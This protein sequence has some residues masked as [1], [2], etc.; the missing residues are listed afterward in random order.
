MTEESLSGTSS[1]KTRRTGHMGRIILD[2][3]KRLNAVDLDMAEGIARTLE[4]WRND[5]KV[6]VVVLESSSPRAFCAG[7]DLKKICELLQIEGADEAFRQMSRVYA[8]MQQIAA[9]P[10][11]TVSVLDGI[12]MGGGIGLGG[13]ATYRIVTE[14]SVVAMPETAIGLT[15]DAGGSW[16]LSR[17]PGFS[18]LRNA[19][20]GN[21]MDGQAAITMGFADTLIASEALPTFLDQLADKL[22]QDVFSA[23]PP[24]PQSVSVQSLDTCYNAPDLDHAIR[25]LT[26]HDSEEARQDLDALSRACPFSVQLAWDAWHR[27][28]SLSSLSDAFQQETALVSCLI[29]RADFAEGVR[30]RL[31]DRDNAPRWHPRT[32]AELDRSEVD[33]CFKHVS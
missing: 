12:A 31:I 6:A 27:A 33:A 18:G 9:Y 28:R 4:A 22:P 3:P 32:L 19:V 5:P 21:R 11:P 20:T 10:K 23:T 1:V 17:A 16:I 2:S 7:G 8:I 30:A 15:P 13:H 26:E 29:R 25:N 24:A 14:R